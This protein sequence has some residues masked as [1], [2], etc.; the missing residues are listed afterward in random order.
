MVNLLIFTNYYELLL[1]KKNDGR[2][3]II[4]TADPK[5]HEYYKELSASYKKE[6]FYEALLYYF[7]N[8]DISNFK[9]LKTPPISNNVF[10][11]FV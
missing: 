3:C 11:G 6:G 9:P 2:Y 5:P 1:P 8:K 7:L 4:R 10:V